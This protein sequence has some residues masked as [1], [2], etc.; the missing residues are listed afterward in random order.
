[1]CLRRQQQAGFSANQRP[2]FIQ[3]AFNEVSDFLETRTRL[4]E[5]EQAQQENV[6]TLEQSHRLTDARYDVGMD[7]YE[8]VLDARW[9]STAPRGRSSQ[10]ASTGSVA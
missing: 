2:K 9:R 6:D 1:M 3:T 10:R 8:A 4:R 5:Q 7:S